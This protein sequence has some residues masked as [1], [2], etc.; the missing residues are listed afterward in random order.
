M[1]FHSKFQGTLKKKQE[2]ICK[3]HQFELVQVKEIKFRLK[4][5]S[6]EILESGFPVNSLPA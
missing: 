3:F 1:G 6:Q 4:D 5:N 2:I